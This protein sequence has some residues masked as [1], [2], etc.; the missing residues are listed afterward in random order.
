MYSKMLLYNLTLG[1]DYLLFLGLNVPHR[2][3]TEL[4]LI[5]FLKLKSKYTPNIFCNPIALGAMR[6][7]SSAY[8]T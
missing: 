7:I 1:Q 2:D 3:F 5:S 4:N 6:Q 8:I